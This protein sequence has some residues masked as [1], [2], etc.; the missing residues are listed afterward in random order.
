MDVQFR[1]FANLTYQLDVISGQA[2][3]DASANYRQLWRS[4]FIR[5]EADQ[6][7]INLWLQRRREAKPIEETSRSVRFPI[8]NLNIGNDI[9]TLMRGNGFEAKD[10]SDYQRRISRYVGKEG[11][12]DLAKVLEAFSPRFHDWW[13]A[14][15]YRKGKPF[16]DSMSELVNSP[17]LKTRVNQFAKFYR[18][19]LPSNT[20]V[21]IYLMYRPNTL[22]ESSSGQQFGKYSV[23][24]FL[25]DEEPSKRI[26]VVIHELC[27]FFYQAAAPATT[28]KL[29]QRF[30]DSKSP[31]AM[32]G[33]NLLNES[34]ATALGNGVITEMVRKPEWFAK[35]LSIDRSFYNSSSIDPAGKAVFGWIKPYLDEGKAIDDPSFVSKYLESV[36][37]RLKDHLRTPAAY[38]VR[39]GIMQDNAVGALSPGY[40]QK[41]FAVASY[42]RATSDFADK[43]DFESFAQNQ[44]LSTI[45]IVSPGKA[46]RLG[47]LGILSPEQAGKVPT[48]SSVTTFWRNPHTVTYVIVASNPEQAEGYLVK[49]S[50]SKTVEVNVDRE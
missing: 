8:E 45:V 9:E 5:S 16:A 1:E 15:A 20:R 2:S 47:D 42:S 7:L 49:I 25:A 44:Y 21:P 22:P 34:M 28:S 4:T 50:K 19:A 14:E 46:S 3:R 12:A 38:L 30:L 27:H 37:A 23:V 11:A 18:T 24:Q 40:L 6:K 36:E 31:I 48:K 29:Q 13:E 10:V 17:E 39:I 26:D 35:Y 43:R 33:Y 32:P 41:Y